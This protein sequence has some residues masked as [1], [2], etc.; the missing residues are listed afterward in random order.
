MRKA[1]TNFSTVKDNE[2]AELTKEI[3]LALTANADFKNPTPSL[4]DVQ[5]A[6][7]EYEDAL[8]KAQSDGTSQEVEHKNVKKAELTKLLSNLATFVNLHADGDLE[9]LKGSGFPLNKAPSA[10]GILL[11]PKSFELSDGDANAIQV[12][13][14][15]VSKASGYIVQYRKDG[16]ESWS[17]ELFSKASGA[18][19]NLTS[20]TKYEFRVAATS[21]ES[22][23]LNE[24]N[25][26]Q[27]KTRVV[28]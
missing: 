7:K 21:A 1:L 6:E 2:L 12:T 11:A 20:V 18:I 14:E 15:S 28:Q 23:K 4:K 26:T 3:I 22:S 13:I 10:V 27:V 25:F 19:K 8:I 5:K 17:S 9:K 24:Y 16:E